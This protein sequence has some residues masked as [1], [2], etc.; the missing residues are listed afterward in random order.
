PQRV[1]GAAKKAIEEFA[2][3]TKDFDPRS[4]LNA[5]AKL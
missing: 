3:A 1:E 5:K 4:E 2:K